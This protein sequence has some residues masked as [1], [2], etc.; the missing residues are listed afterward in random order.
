MKMALP[1]SPR[2]R[3]TSR[4]PMAP[5]TSI[6]CA[7]PGPH[8]VTMRWAA[9]VESVSAA[10]T[11]AAHGLSVRILGRGAA[12][13]AAAERH[14][15]RRVHGHQ[16]GAADDRLGHVLGQRDSAGD[17]QSDLVAQPSLTSRPWTSRRASLMWRG[18]SPSPASRG[19]AGRRQSGTP[20]CRL[21]SPRGSVVRCGALKA[22]G[23]ARRS[24]SG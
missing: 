23:A 10:L 16:I 3:R 4:I 24:G 13:H 8:Q 12:A 19:R 17:D 11:S 5:R 6:N 22:A 14:Q 9:L 21:C 15:Q 1:T 18:R 20:S 7:V 2:R